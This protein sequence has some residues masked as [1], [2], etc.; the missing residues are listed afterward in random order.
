MRVNQSSDKT[1]VIKPNWY[2]A[3]SNYEKPS[4]RKGVFQLADTYIPYLTLW[5]VMVRMVHQH[6][7]YWIILPLAFL[8]TALLGRIFIFFH[9][10][11][12]GS[13]FASRLANTILGYVSGILTFTPYEDWRRAHARH[14]TTAGDLDRRGVGDVWMLTVEEYMALPGLKRLAYRLFRNPF[15][16]FG[17][18]PT[19]LFFI[20]HR[21]PHKSARRSEWYSA[22]FTDLA[23][24]AIIVVASMAIGLRTY[25]LIQMPILIFA[26]TGAVWV[27]YI[28][29]QFDGVYWARHEH[30]DSMKVALEG[31]SYYKLPRVLQW[32][33]GNIGLHHVHHLRPRIPNYNLQQCYDNI[34]A[35][36]V[37]EPLTIRR[38]LK[39]LRL[40]LWDERNGKLVSFRSIKMHAQQGKFQT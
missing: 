1:Q 24:L 14:H 29:H 15:V 20:A 23:I 5:A 13:F 22:I 31:S 18:I 12:H 3:L 8:A 39:S 28:Q 21:F 40:N 26:G 2:Q 36:Q 33:S 37:V 7:P 6:Y 34:P 30:C 17:L 9:D 11:C 38:S 27:F 32:V 25:F 19:V 4:F 10:S 35:V 16:L